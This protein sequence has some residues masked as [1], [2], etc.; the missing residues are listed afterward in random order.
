MLLTL[1]IT[2]LTFFGVS[3]F[4]LLPF[5][6]PCTAHAFFSGCLSN[7]CQGLHH[8][9]SEICTTF[10]VHSLLD[11][12]LN[13]IR[14]DTYLQ[15]KGCEISARPLSCMKF[16]ALTPRMCWYYHLPIMLHYNNCCTD[17]RTSTRNYG[18][19]YPVDMSFL[20][21]ILSSVDVSSSD[22]DWIIGR[23]QPDVGEAVI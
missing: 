5:K 22:C 2:C 21:L 15:M 20:I 18:W 3:E 16:C 6:H 13:H 12:S 19:Q 4:G 8:I 11:P 23:A 17:E 10:D 9:L 14:P 1:L 7:H